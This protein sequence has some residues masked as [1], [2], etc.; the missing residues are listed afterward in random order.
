L[1]VRALPFNTHTESL[2]LEDLVRGLGFSSR[3]S[4]SA[5]LDLP[6]D[7]KLTD[8][9]SHSWVLATLLKHAGV[10]FLHIGCNG[11]PLR[12]SPFSS[13]GRGRMARGS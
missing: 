1:V 13:G 7:A 10:E 8:V 2:E 4:R 12:M 6:R 9:P 5:N 11:V 3:L